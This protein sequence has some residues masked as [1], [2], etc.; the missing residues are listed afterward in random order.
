VY[1][2]DETTIRVT[3]RGVSVA[4][5]EEPII[6]YKV[7]YWQT[8]QPMASA[9]EAYKYLD[10]QDLEAIIPGLTPGKTYKLR[11]LAYSK[12]GDGKMSSPAWEFKVGSLV[13]I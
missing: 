5:N 7:R 10:G 12:G 11:V 1:A 9:K 4:S 3:W 13:S 2:V 6:G 8:D